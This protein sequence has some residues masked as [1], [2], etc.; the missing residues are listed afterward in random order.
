MQVGERECRFCGRPRLKRT[1]GDVDCVNALRRDMNGGWKRPKEGESEAVVIPYTNDPVRERICN[2]C[3]RRFWT[4][5][6]TQRLCGANCRRNI[7]LRVDD[8]NEN[9]TH[10]E[11]ARMGRILRGMD[12]RK[13]HK[14]GAFDPPM[15]ARRYEGILAEV[16][17]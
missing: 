15:G 10:A 1:C 8:P 2:Y 14:S 13:R 12:K 7:E 5:D 4:R 17:E 16:G 9:I 3:D 11:R 6:F